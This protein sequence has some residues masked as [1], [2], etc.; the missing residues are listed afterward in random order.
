MPADTTKSWVHNNYSIKY[1][2]MKAQ[3][4]VVGKNRAALAHIE[5]KST[6]IFPT[7]IQLLCR[8]NLGENAV[9]MTAF[10]MC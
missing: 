5:N 2:D 8:C 6:I 1:I 9:E 10:L 3:G 4:K 7:Q